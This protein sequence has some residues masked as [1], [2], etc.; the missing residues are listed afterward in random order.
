MEVYV[1]F[2]RAGEPYCCTPNLD[3]WAKETGRTVET[4]DDPDRGTLIHP[5]F[6]PLT[7]YATQME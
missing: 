5:E 2:D 1:I 3:E 7:W 6:P 4:S